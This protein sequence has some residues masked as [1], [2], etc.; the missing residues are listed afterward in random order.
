MMKTL[1]KKKL[2]MTETVAAMMKKTVE[3]KRFKLRTA[4]TMMILNMR[5]TVKSSYSSR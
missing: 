5:C 4:K 3:V 2:M 1:T